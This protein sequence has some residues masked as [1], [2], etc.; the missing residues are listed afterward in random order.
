MMSLK[1]DMQKD[2]EQYGAGKKGD[3]FQFKKSGLYKIRILSKPVA[4]ATHFF[5][6]G[7]PSSVC[8]G[9]DKGC[10][11]HGGDGPSVKFQ[12]YVLDRADGKVHL[13]EIP[14]SVLSAIAD[15]ETDEDYSFSGY[16]MPYDVKITV[17]K[18]NT[19]PKQ[20]YKLVPSPA[21]TE[22]TAAEQA[23]LDQKLSKMT[24]EVYVEKR[25][26]DALQKHKDDGTYEREME[27]RGKLDAELKQAMEENAGKE[28][29]I[30]YP[31]E[32]INP[33]DIPF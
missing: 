14:W 10:P 33:E 20:I 15:L 29:A 16:P 32:E 3:F 21:K 24:V 22:L 9:E 7:V 8:Y 12:T 11:F 2:Q 27:R 19:D 25:K 1:D 4:L 17:D 5:G 28:P 31:D 26:N 13:G 30:K 18:E 23:E 6:K